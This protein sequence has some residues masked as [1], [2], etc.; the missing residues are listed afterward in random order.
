MTPKSPRLRLIPCA[1][2]AA[3]QEAITR[4]Q[5]KLASRKRSG[6]PA[7]SDILIDS[8]N[9]NIKGIRLNEKYQLPYFNLAPGLLFQSMRGLLDERVAAERRPAALVRLR[10]YAGLAPG[11]TPLTDQAIAYTRARFANKSLIGPFKD[12]LER[13]LSN[14]D[15]YMTGIEQLFKQFGIK[16][17][18]GPLAEMK[19][20]IAAYNDF[21]RT[22]VMP[23]TPP[24]SASRPSFI[25]THWKP[26]ATKCRSK[27]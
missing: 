2:I 10:K 25:N 7:G 11:T 18:E 27:S 16:D 20:Q 26:A 22:E 9:D 8:A 3:F 19:K 5:T 1:N 21:L 12:D 23:C 15:R 17:Y 13:D 14:S 24:T 6:C 4:L